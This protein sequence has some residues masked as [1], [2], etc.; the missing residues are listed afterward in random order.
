MTVPYLQFMGGYW[1]RNF[2]PDPTEDFSLALDNGVKSLGGS[3]L[4]MSISQFSDFAKE[5]LRLPLKFKM[6]GFGMLQATNHQFVKF[7]NM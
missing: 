4:G 7:L 6:K 1:I 5:R 2:L 3:F